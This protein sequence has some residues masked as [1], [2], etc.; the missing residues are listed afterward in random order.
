MNASSH[1]KVMDG[2]VS[3]VYILYEYGELEYNMDH[4]VLYW[5]RLIIIKYTQTFGNIE[6]I[7]SIY[8]IIHTHTVYIFFIR[9]A[10]VS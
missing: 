8:M 4:M 2:S 1:N 6:G 3:S 7:P 10:F 5:S 9:S